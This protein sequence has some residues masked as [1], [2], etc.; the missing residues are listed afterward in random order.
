M[1]NVNCKKNE[2]LHLYLALRRK[3]DNPTLQPL[4]IRKICYDEKDLN[5]LMARIDQYDGVWRIHKT[6]N[7]RSCE[8]A[9]KL[10]MHKLIDNPSSCQ[11]LESLWK[12]CLL[13]PESR[14]ERNFLIDFDGKDATPMQDHLKKH[15]VNTIE[16]G[17][18][19]FTPNG[20]HFITKP[21]DIRILE[22]F[23]EVTVHRDGYV[24]VGMHGKEVKKLDT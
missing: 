2:F 3:K 17:K 13:K 19:F 24:F 18:G 12:T 15:G 11:Q 21:F 5:I 20:V 23:K 9:A 22:D 14:A 16:F 6:V 8:K 7:K 1:K 10:L 4:C